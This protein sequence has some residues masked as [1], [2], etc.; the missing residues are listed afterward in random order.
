M[1]EV[2]CLK[3]GNFQNLETNG[4]HVGGRPLRA[5][6]YTNLG[7]VGAGKAGANLIA[8]TSLTPNAVHVIIGNGAADSVV[9]TMPALAAVPALGTFYTFVLGA[10]S[11]STDSGADGHTIKL[12]AAGPGGGWLCGSVRLVRATAGAAHASNTTELVH[13]FPLSGTDEMIHMQ[14]N[15]AVG[16]GEPGSFVTLTYIGLVDGTNPGWFVDGTIVSSTIASTGANSFAPH[17]AM[18]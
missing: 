17:A 7:T 18:D 16:G 12:P 1:A 14:S 10:R 11:T 2:G 4:L 3:D 13:V 5:A 8:A 9:V 15:D 6:A